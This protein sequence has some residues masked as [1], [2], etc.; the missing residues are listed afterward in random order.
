M[1]WIVS[2]YAEALRRDSYVEALTPVTQNVIVFGNK[3]FEEIIKLKGGLY[4][5]YTLLYIK[6]YI[7]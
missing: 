1:S 5:I 2:P 4:I 6:Q 7:H 3:V